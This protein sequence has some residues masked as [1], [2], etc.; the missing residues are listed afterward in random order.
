M[1][2]LRKGGLGA[3]KKD[4]QTFELADRLSGLIVGIIVT[5]T[6]DTAK[7]GQA[8]SVGNIAVAVPFIFL[9][10]CVRPIV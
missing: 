3:D 7:T 2:A 8:K 5:P 1:V 9:D 6:P 10:R 4:H